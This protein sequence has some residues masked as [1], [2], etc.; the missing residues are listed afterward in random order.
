MNSPLVSV[1]V[2]GVIVAQLLPRAVLG[3]F[4]HALRTLLVTVRVPTLVRPALDMNVHLV[5]AQ[6]CPVQEPFS[7]VR[8]EKPILG[9]VH[10][11]V[12]S[13]PLQVLEGLVAE[14]AELGVVD[15]ADVLG[16]VESGAEDFTAGNAG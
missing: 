14:G 9:V 16:L 3:A 8:A 10:V 11:H 7:T 4:L 13:V 1:P 15:F 6:T 5:T 2:G 12:L